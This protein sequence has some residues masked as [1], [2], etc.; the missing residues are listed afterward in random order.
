LIP[1]RISLASIALLLVFWASACSGTNSQ[2][3]TDTASDRIQSEHLSTV[4]AKDFDPTNFDNSTTVDNKW[5]PLVPGDHSVFEGSAIDD[6][7]RISRR[8][9]ST[10]TDLSKQINGVNTIVVWE[11]DYS[12]GE[13]VE[14]ELAFFAQDDYGNVW[15]MGE[16]PEEYEEGEFE[17]AP[18]WLAGFKGAWAG[19][20]MRA[21]P[22]LK[23]PS[24]AQGYAPPPST[25]STAGGSTR[26]ARKAVCPSI[27]TTR[28]L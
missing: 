10:V 18:G 14:A 12:E 26:L 5:F 24:Y 21:E 23:T 4:G 16:Y 27:A 3:A 15:H 22:R 8:V 11:R 7:E 9:V 20:A 13:L 28:C 19:I 25:G 6:G 2:S 1:R 17:K